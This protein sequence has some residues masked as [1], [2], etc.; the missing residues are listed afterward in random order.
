MIEEKSFFLDTKSYYIN[1][2]KI[3]SKSKTC[4][5]YFVENNSRDLTPLL[6]SLI[7]LMLD[8]FYRTQSGFQAL[9]EKEWVALGHNFTDRIGLLVDSE[10]VG[11]LKGPYVKYMK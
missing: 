6:T 1:K 10:P 5:F 3:S 9:I 4:Y 2:M 8:P 11:Y 7:Q